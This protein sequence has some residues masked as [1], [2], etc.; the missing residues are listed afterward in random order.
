MH[1]IILSLT[2]FIILTTACTSQ[3]PPTPTQTAAP[4]ATITL[5]ATATTVPPTPSP[6]PTPTE[7]V[8]VPPPTETWMGEF[9]ANKEGYDYSFENG[10]WLM[11][12]KPLTNGKTIDMFT[13]AD[14][15]WQPTYATL[16]N[17]VNEYFGLDLEAVAHQFVRYELTT[18][19]EGNS[20]HT[21]NPDDLANLRALAETRW[22]ERKEQLG[23]FI[24]KSRSG[25]D[26]ITLSADGALLFDKPIQQFSLNNLDERW[27]VLAAAS[28]GDQGK[29][30]VIF[31]GTKYGLI[32]MIIVANS[33]I[34]KNPYMGFTPGE[35]HIATQPLI[36]NPDLMTLNHFTFE[37]AP[38]DRI[39]QNTGYT[40]SSESLDYFLSY[41]RGAENIKPF[42]QELMQ[43]GYYVELENIIS[44][45]EQN[46]LIF[47]PHV[48]HSQLTASQFYKD[49]NTD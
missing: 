1:R 13:F 2:I 23:S 39:K 10:Q 22:E 36:E 37:V 27:E 40:Y 6:Q 47:V 18:D 46:D 21:L 19:S 33:G 34:V 32:P 16:P 12:S 29:D 48:A 43:S 35:I 49:S 4:S 28:T 3:Q 25:P 14:G 9:L 41:L 17:H 11:R 42:L 8:A 26:L 31:I 45:I 44:I 7:T 38:S 5:T 15:E 20:V 24:L 30:Q